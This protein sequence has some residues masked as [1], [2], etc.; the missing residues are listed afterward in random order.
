MEH[1]ERCKNR[2]SQHRK[3]EK[4]DQRI[5]VQ[6]RAPNIGTAFSCHRK[7]LHTEKEAGVGKIN[8][9]GKKGDEKQTKEHGVYDPADGIPQIGGDG[10]NK[11]D[12]KN[13]E[14]DTGHKHQPVKIIHKA[15]EKPDINIHKHQ[16]QR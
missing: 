1:F 10:H 5:G 13:R 12:P 3:T 9:V 2:R 15:G 16:G 14:K 8:G 11:A 6:E 4:I 7:E